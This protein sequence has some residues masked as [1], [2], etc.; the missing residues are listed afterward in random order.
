MKTNKASRKIRAH[1][2][3]T[4][5]DYAYLSEKGYSNAEILAIWDRDTAWGKEPATRYAAIPDIVGY[6][7]K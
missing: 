3:Y 6:L 1:K 5:V 2:Q 4:E 7:N